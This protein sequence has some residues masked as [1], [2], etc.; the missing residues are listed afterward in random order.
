MT[1]NAGENIKASDF[2]NE[3]EKNA[4]PSNDEGRVPRLE[5]DGQISSVFG[6]V[7]VQE[8]TADGTWTK[9]VK[10]SWVFIEAWGAGGGGGAGSDATSNLSYARG[11]AGGEHVAMMLP[12]YMLDATESVSVG[13]GASAVATPETAVSGGDGE[14]TIFGSFLTANG[15]EGGDAVINSGSNPSSASGGTGGSSTYNQLNIENGSSSASTSVHAGGGGA[16]ASWNSSG[17]G[18]VSTYGGNGGDSANG[19][20]AIGE[21]GGLRGGGGGAV[22]SNAGGTITSGEGKGY[23]KI[24]TF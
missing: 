9:P 6:T 2:I 23:I 14:D 15:G 12:A 17:S 8:F 21:D 16:D 19:S 13:V 18:A 11:G 3:S 22:A 4:T 5:D 24:T 10:G 1:I 7:D 20:S